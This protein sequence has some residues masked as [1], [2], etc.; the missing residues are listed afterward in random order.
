MFFVV[1]VF[2]LE[3]FFERRA[4]FFNLFFRIFVF[5]RPLAQETLLEHFRHKKI[6]N[7]IHIVQVLIVFNFTHLVVVHRQIRDFDIKARPASFA[8]HLKIPNL[9]MNNDKMGEVKDD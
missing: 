4:G 8:V 1:Q 2:R 6:F 7:S 5:H 3:E 9:S